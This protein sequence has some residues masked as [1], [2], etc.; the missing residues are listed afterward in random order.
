[1]GVVWPPKLAHLACP[2]QQQPPPRLKMGSPIETIV[3]LRLFYKRLA[4]RSCEG[5]FVG[6]GRRPSG[7]AACCGPLSLGRCA[8]GS[9]C[10]GVPW[11]SAVRRWQ[12]GPGGGLNWH[13]GLGKQQTWWFWIFLVDPWCSGAVPGLGPR[14]AVPGLFRVVVRLQAKF[15]LSHYFHI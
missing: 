1:V 7:P 5:G 3:P 11:C 13:R 15:I 6:Q 9:G 10:F 2:I 14:S 4:Q 12:A 8:K